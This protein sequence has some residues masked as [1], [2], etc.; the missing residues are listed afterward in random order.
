MDSEGFNYEVIDKFSVILVCQKFRAA[1]QNVTAGPPEQKR[2][3]IGRE[4]AQGFEPSPPGWVKFEVWDPSNREVLIF[5]GF[6]E[7]QG[8]QL[9]S[10]R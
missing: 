9:R 3:T 1:L 5:F 6:R 2:R 10:Y 8:F 7:F 4:V